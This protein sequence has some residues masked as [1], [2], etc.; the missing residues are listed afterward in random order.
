MKDLS[1]PVY[2]IFL[3]IEGNVFR[4]AEVLHCIRNAYPK[5]TADPEKMID[6]GLACKY[7]SSK[8]KNIDLLLA[9]ILG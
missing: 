8:I 7:Y 3:E 5:F 4:D 2:N 6:A 9:K 1:L